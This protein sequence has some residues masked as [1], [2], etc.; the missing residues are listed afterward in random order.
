MVEL[1]MILSFPAAAVLIR[2][3]FT[4]CSLLCAQLYAEC[5]MS[6]TL[7]LLACS[8]EWPLLRSSPSSTQL[9]STRVSN[10]S[11]PSTTLERCAPAAEPTQL[12]QPSQGVHPACLMCCVCLLLDLKHRWL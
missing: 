10:P 5:H 4:V 3:I 11:R 2:A 8:R 7:C 1:R 12:G 6:L 9:A